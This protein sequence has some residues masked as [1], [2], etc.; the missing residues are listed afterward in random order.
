MDINLTFL[1][2]NATGGNESPNGSGIFTRKPL[3]SSIVGL[4]RFYDSGEENITVGRIPCPAAPL[5]YRTISSNLGYVFH[6][7]I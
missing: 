2:E 7:L 6:Y 3:K 1:P 5:L 4:H